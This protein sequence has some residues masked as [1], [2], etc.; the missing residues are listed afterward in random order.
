[1]LYF[2]LNNRNKKNI[3]QLL[4]HFNLMFSFITSYFLLIL[5]IFLIK[6]WIYIKLFFKWE[7]TFAILIEIL[8]QNCVRHFE[9]GPWKSSF[10]RPDWRGLFSSVSTYLFVHSDQI[11]A[12][13][14]IVKGKI[15]RAT[16]LKENLPNQLEKGNVRGIDV[17]LSDNQFFEQLMSFRFLLFCCWTKLL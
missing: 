17:R 16:G 3:N 15:A 7:V 5:G 14:Y 1:M 4:T 8:L 11:S 6:V 12:L 9:F 13:D 10:L 2:W